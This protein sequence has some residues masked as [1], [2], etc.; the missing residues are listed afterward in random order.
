[1]AVA[2]NRLARQDDEWFDEPDELDRLQRALDAI[3]D[4]DDPRIAAAVLAYRAARAQAFGR[5][6]ESLP[7]R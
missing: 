6:P 7:G 5:T 3:A 4:I 2:F 1:M